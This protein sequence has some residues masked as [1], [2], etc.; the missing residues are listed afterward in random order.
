MAKQRMYAA[1]GTWTRSW[2][3]SD[4]LPLAR[5]LHPAPHPIGRAEAGL[6]GNAFEF[7]TEAVT[8][9]LE[10]AHVVA[11]S[12]DEQVDLAVALLGVFAQPPGIAREAGDA[13]RRGLVGAAQREASHGH[14]FRPVAADQRRGAKPEA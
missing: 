7:S 1:S 2:T 14:R 9:Q 12:G 10:V 13:T 3:T 5:G 8:L 4:R 11:E 6:G